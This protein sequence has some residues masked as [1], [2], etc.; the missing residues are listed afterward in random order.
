MIDVSYVPRIVSILITITIGDWVVYIG[1]LSVSGHKKEP[2]DMTFALIK[3]N[4][5]NLELQLY[6]LFLCKYVTFF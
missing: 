3:V 2:C 5:A 4:K 6:V 1:K